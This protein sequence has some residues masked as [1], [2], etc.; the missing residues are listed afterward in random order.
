MLGVPVCQF[1]RDK[2]VMDRWHGWANYCSVRAD[3]AFGRVS[4]VAERD[5]EGCGCKSE[6]TTARRWFD[7]TTGQYWLIR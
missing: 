3:R 2:P 1:G 5:G 4:L 7:S 6:D